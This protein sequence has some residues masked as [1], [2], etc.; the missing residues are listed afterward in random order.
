LDPY[1]P[2]EEDGKMVL[3]KIGA[4]AIHREPLMEAWKKRQVKSER[5]K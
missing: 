5:N 1:V 2:I 4:F 3:P